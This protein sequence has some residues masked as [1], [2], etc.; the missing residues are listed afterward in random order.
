MVPDI[1]SLPD[2]AVAGPST[3]GVPRWP[4]H[5]GTHSRRREPRIAYP[6]HAK[7]WSEWIGLAWLDLASIAAWLLGLIAILISSRWETILLVTAAMFGFLTWHGRR[8]QAA[9]AESVRVSGENQRLLAEQ[10]RFL[11]DASHQL[12]TPITIALGHSELLAKHLVDHGDKRDI[13]I[14]VGELNR[15]LPRNSLIS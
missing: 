13:D 11:Q 2:S 14:V 8:R 7:S 6:D 10:Q 9:S 12:R 3:A 15:T 4:T 5:R 1:D